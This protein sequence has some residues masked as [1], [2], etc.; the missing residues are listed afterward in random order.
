M[1]TRLERVF[2][3]PLDV[4]VV[5]IESNGAAILLVTVQVEKAWRSRDH[6]KIELCG[7]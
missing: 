3:D 7:I 1:R 4:A 6:S 2:H 5:D